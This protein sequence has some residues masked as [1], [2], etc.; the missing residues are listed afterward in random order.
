MDL[1]GCRFIYAGTPSEFYGLRFVNCETSEYKKINGTTKSI[2][3][4]NERNRRN[5]YI[6]DDYSSSP[7][8]IDIEVATDSGDVLSTSV[9]REVENWLFNRRTYSKLY[10][11]PEDD[12]SGETYDEI[13]GER[14]YCYLNCRFTNP[15][16]ITGNG[17][18]VGFKATMECDSN[19]LWQDSTVKTFEFESSGDVAKAKVYTFN[20]STAGTSVGNINIDISPALNEAG[21]DFVGRTSMAIKRTGKN[22]WGGTA[23]KDSLVG[24]GATADEASGTVE[25]AASRFSGSPTLLDGC[26]KDDTVYTI[27][28]RGL[29]SVSS[30]KRSNIGVQYTDGTTA[31]ISFSTAGE[32][33]DVVYTTSSTKTVK[34]IYGS[35]YSGTVSFEYDKCG[36]FEGAVSLDEYAEYC[37]DT[38][39]ID[40]QNIAG[41]VY[42]GVLKMPG[43]VLTKTYEYIES[44]NGE[45]INGEWF[46]TLDI[47]ESGTL[48]SAGA[49]VVY[50]LDSPAVYHLD[51]GV[52]DTLAGENN[53]WSDAGDI[54]VDTS[55]SSEEIVILEVDSDGFD[56]VYPKVIFTLGSSGGDISIIN[57]SDDNSR[58]TSF[59]SL[60]GY[61]EFTMNSELNSIS[62]NNYTK[63]YDKNF[64]RLVP[65]ENILNILGNVAKIKIEWANRRYL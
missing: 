14:K 54:A 4:F 5:Y 43:G 27:I 46:S 48:P 18:T 52:I 34:R 57:T 53:L 40:W 61:T 26:F 37:G 16:K 41:A 17:G 50:K 32:V 22:L 24:L 45:A 38:Y 9:V 29:Y 59:K 62:G 42:G 60:S 28:L 39:V 25:I 63:F 65:G 20:S 19:L 35:S 58:M 47:Y 3:V 55:S 1:S 44:Y 33:S 51:S 15:S 49:K 6:D 21:D 11:D 31:I 64:I 36:V 56:Y 23:F 2:S 30:A 10:I 7:I 12:C 8:S 13:D